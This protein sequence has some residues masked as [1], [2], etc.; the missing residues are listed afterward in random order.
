MSS[1]IP[2][3]LPFRPFA[4]SRSLRA[5]YLSRST[6]PC[7]QAVGVGSNCEEPFPLVRHPGGGSADNSPAEIE[8]HGGNL[9]DHSE[10]GAAVVVGEEAADILEDHP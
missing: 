8:P 9:P 5:R 1:G 6:S 10:S 4:F 7:T 3:P 2:K